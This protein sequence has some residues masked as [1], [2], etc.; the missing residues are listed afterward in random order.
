MVLCRFCKTKGIKDIFKNQLGKDI[1]NY[2]IKYKE[3][4]WED[5]LN[6]FV[7]DNS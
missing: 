4:S 1:S 5:D 6:N 7:S 2:K 3:Y